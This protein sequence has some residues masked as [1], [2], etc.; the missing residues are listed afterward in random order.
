MSGPEAF[1][2]REI[3]AAWGSHPR[4][5]IAR[6]NVGVGWFAKGQPARQT[7]PGAYPVKFGVDGLADIC[8]VIAPEGR[9]LMIEVKS[10]R[11]VLSPEQRV[12][13][14]VITRFGG[15]FV[16]AR[17]VADVDAALAPLGITR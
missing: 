11:G 2:Q 13:Q 10:A 5:R 16:V 8:G 1:I 4:L 15:V 9:L 6:L 7:D 12:M 14:R 17:S 3:L